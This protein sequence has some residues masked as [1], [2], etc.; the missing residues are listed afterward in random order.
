[1]FPEQTLPHDAMKTNPPDLK[2]DEELNPL[3]TIHLLYYQKILQKQEFWNKMK[4]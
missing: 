2:K 3:Y 1:L 4:K